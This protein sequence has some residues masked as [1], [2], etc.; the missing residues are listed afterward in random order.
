MRAPR[1]QFVVAAAGLLASTALGVCALGVALGAEV[2]ELDRAVALCLSLIGLT[3]ILTAAANLL[4]VFPFDGG[5]LVHALLWR[6]ERDERAASRELQRGGRGFSQA[7]AALGLALIS[8]PGELLIGI[9]VFL[10]GVYLLHL[11][12][13]P[14]SL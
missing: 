4:P 6:A 9:A 13:P 12:P 5:K 1:E 8:W 3:N 14:V 2:L 7:V 11:P 10:F